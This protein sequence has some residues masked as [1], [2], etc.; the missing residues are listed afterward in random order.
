MGRLTMPTTPGC[1]LR[2][3]L[4]VL[5]SITEAMK[6]ALTYDMTVVPA[7]PPRCKRPAKAAQPVEIK[8]PQVVQHTPRGRAWR[9]ELETEVEAEAGVAEFFDKMIRPRR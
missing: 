2:T 8:A 3:S 9:V 5:E 7:R 1:P 6:E 4:K